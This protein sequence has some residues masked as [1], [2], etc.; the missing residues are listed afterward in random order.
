MKYFK[1]IYIAYFTSVFCNWTFSESPIL[2]SSHCSNVLTFN[3]V[4]KLSHVVCFRHE[5]AL[6]TVLVCSVPGYINFTRWKPHAVR[7]VH[8]FIGI[9][10][11][12]PP[13]IRRVV[14]IVTAKRI[15]PI[16]CRGCLWACVR[17]W[18]DK[19]INVPDVE[20]FGA[21]TDRF[22]KVIG[23]GSVTSLKNLLWCIDGWKKLLIATKNEKEKYWNLSHPFIIIM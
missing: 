20:N 12:A 23:G 15:V 11:I 16:G 1:T 6:I 8:S 14:V 10:I 5:N 7:V 2:N 4:E 18:F 9:T 17:V 13:T 22:Q 21:V 19:C 3:A